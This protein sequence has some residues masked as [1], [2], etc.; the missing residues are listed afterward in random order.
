MRPNNLWRGGDRFLSPNN[1]MLYYYSGKYS[2]WKA[3]VFQ[4]EK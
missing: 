4:M 1:Y 3:Q 2:D